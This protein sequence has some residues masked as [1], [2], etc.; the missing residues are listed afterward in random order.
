MMLFIWFS[1]MVSG[2]SN[3]DEAA[4][5]QV[6]WF[7]VDSVTPDVRRK[8]YSRQ[9]TLLLARWYVVKG[10]TMF[11]ASKRLGL[12]KSKHSCS[13]ILRVCILQSFSS[14]YVCHTSHGWPH[15]CTK[16]GISRF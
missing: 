8:S 2:E 14:N 15:F 6:K 11:P 9:I 13:F 16:R 3:I 4:N 1:R 5:Q 7:G 10:R 12:I